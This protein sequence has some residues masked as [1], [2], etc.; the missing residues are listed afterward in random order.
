[1]TPNERIVQAAYDVLRGDVDAEPHEAGLCLALV[2]VV[3]ER[4]FYGG[5]WRF[6]DLHRSVVVQP[7]ERASDAPYARDLEAA[8][9]AQGM[10]VSLART[11]PAGDPVRYVDDDALRD[12]EPGVICFRWD[13]AKDRNG[14]YVGHVAIVL[15]GRLI[16]ENVASRHGSLSRGPTKL[17]RL[18]AWPVTTVIQYEPVT[19]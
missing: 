13:T 5:H 17:S 14:V 18:G 19:L 7:D 10:A 4:A 12:V 3:I 8:L 6:Y 15:P 16:L 2:R 9:R 1:M 11:G